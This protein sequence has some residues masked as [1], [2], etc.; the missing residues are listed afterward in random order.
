[1]D[2]TIKEMLVEFLQIIVGPKSS[3]SQ[4]YGAKIMYTEK[5]LSQ[6]TMIKDVFQTKKDNN[7]MFN[8]R[9]QI[10]IRSQKRIKSTQ[11]FQ[12][13][14]NI[15]IQSALNNNDKLK[16]SDD[17]ISYSIINLGKLFWS[18]NSGVIFNKVSSLPVVKVHKLL[19]D[20]S[21]AVELLENNDSF[22][23]VVTNKDDV[24]IPQNI[25]VDIPSKNNNQELVPV[26]LS[27]KK[28]SNQIFNC[29]TVKY[30]V[31]TNN[32][33]VGIPKKIKDVDIPKNIKG[34]YTSK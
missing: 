34:Q 1:M 20:N 3:S 16:I 5:I 30:H 25:H 27:T 17:N 6:E 2:D 12:G 23:R 14:S 18:I 9:T 28:V 13:K 10:I 8:M 33:D 7:V 32:N 22:L 24:D 31:S 15:P 19:L 21:F 11:K 26:K 4:D 29:D